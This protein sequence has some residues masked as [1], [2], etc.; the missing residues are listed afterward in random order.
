MQNLEESLACL[1]KMPY[2]YEEAKS[3]LKYHYNHLERSHL[4]DTSM[5]ESA[6]EIHG[7]YTTDQILVALGKH[8][9][10]K[11]YHFQEGVLW[12]KEKNLDAFFITLNKVEKHYSP[13]T[14]Y[15]DY[16]INDT[17]FHWQTQSKVTQ[18]SPT[19]MRYQTHQTKGHKILLF[20]RNHKEENGLTSPFTYLGCGQYVRHYGE[21]PVNIVWQLEHALPADLGA[22]AQKALVL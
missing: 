4:E 5:V 18:S 16:A 1:Y 17:L 8:T 20:V 21:K 22:K 3:I 6:L 12:V 2:L 13:S 7:T 14:M 19:F 15:K 11:K 10:E 9:E